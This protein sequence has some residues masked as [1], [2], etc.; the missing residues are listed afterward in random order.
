[1]LRQEADL[2]LGD[3]LLANREILS[4]LSSILRADQRPSTRKLGLGADFDGRVQAGE[5]VSEILLPIGLCLG[6]FALVGCALVAMEWVILLVLK[7]GEKI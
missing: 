2:L 4:E 7:I 6:A 5:Q 1:M 3:G